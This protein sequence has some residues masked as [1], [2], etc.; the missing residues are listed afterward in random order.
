MVSLA[1]NSMCDSR[2]LFMV[3]DNSLL[4]RRLLLTLQPKF[5]SLLIQLSFNGGCLP[6]PGSS[7]NFKSQHYELWVTPQAR[8]DLFDGCVSMM[9]RHR[10]PPKDCSQVQ[11]PSNSTKDQALCSENCQ[12]CSRSILCIRKAPTIL[13]ARTRA[14]L[15]KLK[16]G[17]FQ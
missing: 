6:L 13:C 2:V 16:A 7:G 8:K 15:K 14:F 9:L 3:T 12:G 1:S 5:K 4:T 11:D 17:P 10:I